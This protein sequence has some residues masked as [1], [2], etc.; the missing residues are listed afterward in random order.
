MNKDEEKLLTLRNEM[1]EAW[2][3]LIQG[4][5]SYALDFS[6]A[7]LRYWADEYVIPYMDELEYV[8]HGP[9]GHPDLD[10]EYQQQL[11]EEE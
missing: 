10:P 6:C 9:R 11:L 8:L 4:P 7:T 5:D 3:V 1:F 2:I